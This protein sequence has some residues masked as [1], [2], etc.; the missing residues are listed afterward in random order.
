VEAL[1]RRAAERVRVRR[2][3]G[4]AVDVAAQPAEVVVERAV[5]LHQHHDG[6]DGN[7]VAVQAAGIGR[8]RRVAGAE[9][10]GWRRLLRADGRGGGEGEGGDQAGGWRHRRRIGPRTAGDLSHSWNGSHLEWNEGAMDGF[11]TVNANP[12]DPT[13]SRAM[14]YY[15]ARDL[16]FYCSLYRTFAISD[17]HFCSLLGPTYP[18]RYYLLTGTSFGHVKNT[19][20]NFSTSDY[21]Q[22]TIFEQLDAADVSWAL[23]YSDAPFAFVFGYPRAHFGTN[24]KPIT[25]YYAD[26]AAGAL[27]QVAFVDPAFLEGEGQNDEHPPINVQKGQLF[28]AGVVNALMASPQW[29]RSALFITYDEHGG[30]WDHVPPPMA[31]AP[32]AIG[33]I[34]GSPWTFDRY[35]VRVPVVVVSPYAKRHYVSHTVTDQTTGLRFIQTQHDLPALTKRDANASPLLEMFDFENPPFMK[36]PK[37]RKAKIDAKRAA[38]CP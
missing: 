6:V 7:L 30:Y 4:R 38:E 9:G 27:P 10:A 1:D 29:T 5:L 18:N 11:T 17:R 2:V 8:R 12:Q 31:C 28:V 13:G 36:P 15:T 24:F 34:G 3:V 20:P 32:D 25:Q 22:P 35:G 19:L 37:L 33:P 14:G 26:A 16:P 21:A 23:Y